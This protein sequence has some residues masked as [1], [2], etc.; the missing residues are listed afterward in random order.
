MSRT[1]GVFGSFRTKGNILISAIRAIFSRRK[2][3]H[4]HIFVHGS[5]NKWSDRKPRRHIMNETMLNAILTAAF[6]GIPAA[7]TVFFSVWLLI[8]ETRKGA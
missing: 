2:K 1:K 8:Y 7:A 4:E 5:K 3:K 6:F